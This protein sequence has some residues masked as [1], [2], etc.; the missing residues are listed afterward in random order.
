MEVRFRV[1][2]KRVMLA[3]AAAALLLT[4]VA[5]GV[6]SNAYTD[7]NGVYHACVNQ[8]SGLIRML[9]SGEACR[10]NEVGVDWNQIG[11]Q[12]LQ[13][14]QGPKGDK[15][16]T[17]P[18]GAQGLQGIQGPQGL[19]GDTGATG[20]QGIQGVKGDK[21]DTGSQ[22]PQGIQGPKGDTGP[23]GPAGVGVS[24]YQ[25]VRGSTNFLNVFEGFTESVTCPAGKRA[26]SG[27]FY[28]SG[29]STDKSYPFS[30]YDASGN[31][32]G[33]KIAGGAGPLGGFI[34]PFAICA[35]V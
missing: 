21:G 7:A 30:P 25:I 11:P 33:W 1:T 14:I 15:G 31:G 6:T 28:G 26:L 22:G 3:V 12:G 5:L 34:V 13:G 4:G 2:R 20:S 32:E 8:G 23:Q 27:G 10:N 24:G 19:K 35:D 29:A 17:G 16:D 9:E 18:Q